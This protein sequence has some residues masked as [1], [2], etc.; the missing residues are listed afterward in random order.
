MPRFLNTASAY[1]EMQQIVTNAKK[2]LV[3]VSPYIQIP[4]EFLNR[5]QDIQKKNVKITVVCRESELKTEEK[6]NLM[7]LQNLELHFEKNL[8]AK[9]FFNEESM[10]I[11]SLNLYDHSVQSNYEMGISLNIFED[12]KIFNDARNEAEHIIGVAKQVSSRGIQVE[13]PLLS[14]KQYQR[15]NNVTNQ[16]RSGDGSIL[17]DIGKLINNVFSDTEAKGYCIRCGHRTNMDKPYCRG[18]YEDW[19]KWE[20]PDHKELYC[21][22]CGRENPSTMNKPICRSCFK[23]SQR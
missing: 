3:L 23:K 10:V 13:N 20:N 12:T 11:G 1:G 7:K 8:H 2:Q 14:P 21:H 22:T 6:D 9:C 19:S 15:E 4:P 16:A 17:Q 5:L 18:C